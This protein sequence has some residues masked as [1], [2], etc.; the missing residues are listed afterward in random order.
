MWLKE[1]SDKRCCKQ[2]EAQEPVIGLAAHMD[3]S[4]VLSS[5]TLMQ[6]KMIRHNCTGIYSLKE[7]VYFFVV[8]AAAFTKCPVLF[9]LVLFYLKFNCV[10]SSS[11]FMTVLSKH[12]S[13]KYE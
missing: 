4:H 11:D 2:M 13:Y 5:Q 10:P 3:S 6:A 8:V 7:S 1:I 9:C 12:R